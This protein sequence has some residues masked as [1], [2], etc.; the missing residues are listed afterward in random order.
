MTSQSKTT[1]DDLPP[2]IRWAIHEYIA[3]D[4]FWD[5]VSRF[6]AFKRF[7]QWTNQLTGEAALVYDSL[8]PGQ[9]FT[10]NYRFIARF[11]PEFK[12]MVRS[13]LF[14]PFGTKTIFRAISG[15]ESTH[16][17]VDP[18]GEI[19]IG[20]LRLHREGTGIRVSRRNYPYEPIHEDEPMAILVDQD[21][22]EILRFSEVVDK[23]GWN[24][25][26]LIPARF[27]LEAITS[28]PRRWVGEKYFVL[29][30]L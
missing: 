21:K 20:W 3:P 28:W 9:Y 12:C 2:E 5:R 10:N 8:P 11:N 27:L 13:E 7:V 1:F 25:R 19:R 15:T 4:V 30:P 14:N 26:Y 24:R 6:F 16:F 18:D 22:L 29:N 17:F 23:I